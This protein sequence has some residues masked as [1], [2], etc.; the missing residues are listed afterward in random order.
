MSIITPGNPALSADQ[1]EM[2]NARAQQAA[3]MQVLK[4]A[5]DMACE[6]CQ[7]LNFLQVV[8]LKKLSGLITGTGKDAVIPIPIYACASCGHVNAFFLQ[9]LDGDTKAA[10]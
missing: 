9:K 4:D 10:E 3:L 2:A 5:S 7:E 6:K 8:R 1:V